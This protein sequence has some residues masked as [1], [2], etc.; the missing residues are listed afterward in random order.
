MS[1]RLLPP[2]TLRNIGLLVD[3]GMTNAG[4]L[5]LSRNIVRFVVSATITCALFQGTTKTKILDQK[6]F[7]EDVAS[8]F[9]NTLLYL[10]SHLNTEYIISAMREMKLEL[11]EA[12]L[13]EALTNAIAHRDY[14]SSANVQSISSPIASRF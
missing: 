14:R 5:V 10:Q 9:R 1:R 7:S 8:N 6:V 11:P 4:C 2:T 3:E 12:A 13:R